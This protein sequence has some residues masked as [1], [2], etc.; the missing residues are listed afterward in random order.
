[1]KKNMKQMSM[2]IKALDKFCKTNNKRIE[3]DKGKLKGFMGEY[4]V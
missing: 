1:M 4:Y 3:V 2:G